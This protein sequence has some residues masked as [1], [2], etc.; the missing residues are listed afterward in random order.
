ME[1]YGFPHEGKFTAKEVRKIADDF[2]N[3]KG[4]NIYEDCGDGV[5]LCAVKTIDCQAALRQG[6]DAIERLGSVEKERDN[7]AFTCEELRNRLAA[8]MKVAEDQVKATKG[9]Y[10]VVNYRD[11]C[12]IAETI[13]SVAQGNGGQEK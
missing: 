5:S 8:I 6:A 11:V 4:F 2:D 7:Q 3:G 12:K 10:G 9:Q 1:A 13:I